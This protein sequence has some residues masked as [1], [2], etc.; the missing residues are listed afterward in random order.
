MR[1]REFIECKV[2]QPPMTEEKPAYQA[3]FEGEGNFMKK[4]IYV[5]VLI[6]FDLLYWISI[7]R[8]YVQ[9]IFNQ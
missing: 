7:D 4:L 6:G 8:N 1:C 2:R 9:I 3:G 5:N